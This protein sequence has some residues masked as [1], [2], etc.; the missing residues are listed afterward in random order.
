MPFSTPH[1]KEEHNMKRFDE[2]EMII[3][4]FAIADIIATSGREDEFPLVPADLADL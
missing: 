2:P 3:T 4:Q 1:S